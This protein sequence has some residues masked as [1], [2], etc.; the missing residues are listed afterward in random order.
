[1][2]KW[3]QMEPKTAGNIDSLAPAAHRV[4]AALRTRIQSGVYAVNQ[5]LPTQR[6][7]AQEFRVHRRAVNSAIEALA[8]EGL[9]HCRSGCRPIVVSQARNGSRRIAAR[10]AGEVRPDDNTADKEEP[11]RLVALLMW[12][13]GNTDVVNAQHRIFRGMNDILADAGCHG[14]FLNLGDDLGT[15]QENATREAARLQYALDR[16]FA[17]VIFY[18]HAPRSNR[19]LIQEVAGRMPLVLIDRLVPG[20][21]ADFVGIDNYQAM[22]DLTERLIGLGHRRIGYITRLES[23]NTVGDRLEGYRHAMAHA[24]LSENVMTMPPFTDWTILDRQMSQPA[25]RRPSALMCVHDY[26]AVKVAKHIA[27]LGL[28]V[29]ADVSLTGFDDLLKELPNGFGLTSVAQPFEEIG[30]AAARIV[31]ARRDGAAHSAEHVELLTELVMRESARAVRPT[32]EEHA[33]AALAPGIS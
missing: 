5:W 9:L 4:A 10:R 18:A 7:I 27:S 20:V 33:P 8:S 24:G 12:H 23:I 25:D 22:R 11:S 29:P 26:D 30:R 1:M 17:G 6:E 13:G 19:R 2:L 14:V 28:C 15:D 32:A 16:G 3:H 31:M 21:P